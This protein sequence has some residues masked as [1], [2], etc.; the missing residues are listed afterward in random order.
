MSLLPVGTGRWASGC[1]LG[2]A[3]LGF[4]RRAAGR[5]RWRR[6][7]RFDL[8]AR[9]ILLKRTNG[10][11]EGEIR[12]ASNAAASIERFDECAV[13]RG[14]MRLMRECQVELALD[15]TQI[16]PAGRVCIQRLSEFFHRLSKLHDDD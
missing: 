11:R 14:K 6:R 3:E 5:F 13:R 2:R 10:R 9:L 1:G 15:A 16:E 4:V 8:N 12:L 7:N